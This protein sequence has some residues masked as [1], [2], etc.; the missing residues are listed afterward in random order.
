VVNGIVGNFP[1]VPFAFTVRFRGGV[2][3]RMVWVVLEMEQLGISQREVG[4]L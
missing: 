4:V 2:L 3:A 1:T